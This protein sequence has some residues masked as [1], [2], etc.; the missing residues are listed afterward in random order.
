MKEQQIIDI[1][2]A[3]SLSKALDDLKDHIEV[4]RKHF[5]DF[6]R[7]AQIPLN[8]RWDIYLK[9]G[10]MLLSIN[11]YSFEPDGID[12]NKYTLFDDFYCDKYAT[13]TVDSMT[14]QIEQNEFEVDWIKYK[15]SWLQKGIW[16]FIN[17]W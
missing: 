7:N 10:E 15:E 17:D 4:K 2:S 9:H 6:I 11:T 13:M 1:A 8:L 16:G 5:L 12:W 3:E 14:E